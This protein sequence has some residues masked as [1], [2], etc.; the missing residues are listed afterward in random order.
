MV[1][2][3]SQTSESLNIPVPR[4]IVF[5]FVSI[6][7]YSD[8]PPSFSWLSFEGASKYILQLRGSTGIVWRK[9]VRA[10]SETT[11]TYDG[12][13]LLQPGE[14]YI[15][16]VEVDCQKSYTDYQFA[17]EDRIAKYVKEGIS[18]IKQTDFPN[19]VKSK[20]LAQL[21]DLLIDRNKILNIIQGIIRQGSD[22]EIICFLDDFLAQG[23]AVKLLANISC[24]NDILDGLGLFVSE[25]ATT[26]INLAKYCELS[27][28][29]TSLIKEIGSKGIELALFA[30]SF[31]NE[32]TS[33]INVSSI[34]PDCKSWCQE[35]QYYCGIECRLCAHCQG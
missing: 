28:I 6:T 19:Q 7:S 10:T 14:D 12:E 11:V 27:G 9:E 31:N 23:S 33:Q 3:I 2:N 13:T 1:G 25:L 5:R 8:N 4:L 34:Q 29:S 18:K 15:F 26:R 16:T 30:R 32:M 22:S 20:L 24:Y 17:Q 21:D 35:H